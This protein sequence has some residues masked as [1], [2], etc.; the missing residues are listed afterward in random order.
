M[1]SKTSG[2]LHTN[3]HIGYLYAFL[4][5]LNWRGRHIYYVLTDFYVIKK[6]TP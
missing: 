3:L 2:R 4:Y 1:Y 6:K 5:F